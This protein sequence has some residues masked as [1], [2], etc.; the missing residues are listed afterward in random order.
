MA[1]EGKNQE[2]KNNPARLKHRQKEDGASSKDAE[3]N[4]IPHEDELNEADKKGKGSGKR[5]L[6]IRSKS[7]C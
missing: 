3:G 1:K 6:A 4:T 5:M 2:Y 7:K